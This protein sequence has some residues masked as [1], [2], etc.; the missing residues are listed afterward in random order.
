MSLQEKIEQDRK[1]LQSKLALAKLWALG[2]FEMP[3]ELIPKKECANCYYMTIHE[4]PDGHCYMLEEDPG[5][6]CG[7]FKSNENP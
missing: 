6:R 2:L 7:Q 5:D 3:Q 1:L 4:E